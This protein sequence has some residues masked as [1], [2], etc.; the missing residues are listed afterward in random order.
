MSAA[1]S[2]K[3]TPKA[4]KVRGRET[5]WICELRCTDGRILPASGAEPRLTK[6]RAL[7]DA[8]QAQRGI[9][10]LRYGVGRYRRMP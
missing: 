8:Q 3:S 9:K 6:A 10:C 2:D 1:S 7:Y 5:V 4:R